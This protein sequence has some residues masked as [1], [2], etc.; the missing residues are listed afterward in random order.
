MPGSSSQHFAAP[1]AVRCLRLLDLLADTGKQMTMTEIASRLD[2]PKSTVHHIL[3]A[4][5]EFGWVERDPESLRISLGLRAWEVGQA[6]DLAQSLSQRARSFMDQV[7]DETGETVRLAVRSGSDQV[8][9][10]KS[11]GPQTLVFDQRVGAR[12]PCHATGLGKALLSGLE[13]TEVETLY[14]HGLEPTQ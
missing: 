1:A 4:L 13:A 11:V 8:C 12:L 2:L 6:Y 14:P 5:V 7:R 10:A 3:A 9:M